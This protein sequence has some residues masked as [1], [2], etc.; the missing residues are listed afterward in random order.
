MLCGCTDIARARQTVMY[1]ARV[2]LGFTYAEAGRLVGRD[3]TTAAYACRVIE[4][5]RDDPDFDAK[6]TALESGLTDDRV[7]SHAD[8]GR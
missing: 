8:H 4:D 3:R 6:L 1:L 7:A 5:L 2:V